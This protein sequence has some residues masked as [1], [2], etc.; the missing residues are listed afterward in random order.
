MDDDQHPDPPPHPDDVAALQ[1]SSSPQSAIPGDTLPVRPGAD[2]PTNQGLPPEPG[3]DAGRA[4]PPAPGAT[5]DT[6]TPPAAA[7]SEDAGVQRT[8][9][10]S[11]LD[12]VAQADP[13]ARPDRYSAE[14]LR[15][16]VAGAAVPVPVDTVDR[17]LIQ[18]WKST[19]AGG[20]N[21]GQVAVTLMRAMNLVVYVEDEQRAQ[22]AN[23][24]VSRIT[25]RHPCRTIM[26]VNRSGAAP[27]PAA[28]LTE[29]E[30]GP[31]DAL[32]AKLSAHCQMSAATGKHVCCEQITI[33][34]KTAAALGRVSNVALNLLITDL[35][36]F[37]W[38]AGGA[39]FNNVVLTQLEDSID[40]L[41]IDSAT[42]N[43]P[44]AG[45]LAMART[46][47][48]AFRTAPV[49]RFAPG[50]LNWDRLTGWREATAQLF[51]S[52]DLIASLWRIGSI[53]IQYAAPQG[54]APPNPAQ[55]LLYAGWLATRLGWEFHGAAPPG[56]RATPGDLT[57]TMRQGVR[58][59]PIRLRP[60]GPATA[61]A[62]GLTRMRMVTNDVR[63]TT[64]SIEP[65][66][67]DVFVD[68][69]VEP[70]DGERSIRKVRYSVPD[71]LGLLDTEM[72]LFTHDE[73]YDQALAMA[74][75]MAWGSLSLG[76]RSQISAQINP[77]TRQGSFDPRF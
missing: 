60:D 50:D 22:Q 56:P 23:E 3:P 42:F 74:G 1:Q 6:T 29:A 13:S 17:E 31:E 35:P 44:S 14:A 34:A 38:W 77:E 5:H 21:E 67:D 54:D 62:G 7:Q 66:G 45:L 32:E 43:D 15:D 46:I 53:E 41:I 55:A 2:R 36:V 75:S 40:R 76:R 27:P 9:E 11:N 8:I 20:D 51:D 26:I 59:I 12:A 48:P 49:A 16:I 70:E 19:A 24:V 30:P 10:N 47:D 33:E 25:A 65:S 58:S 39:P 73:I 4:M 64:F 68:A 37:L 57:V 61:A 72:E 18:V 52:P 63:P 69:V 71:E 28:S